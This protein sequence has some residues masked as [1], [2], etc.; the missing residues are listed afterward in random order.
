VALLS[1]PL[2]LMRILDDEPSS[3]APLPRSA[4]LAAGLVP[5]DQRRW[6]ANHDSKPLQLRAFADIDVQRY[7]AYQDIAG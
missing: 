4:L 5:G 6:S 7:S 3:T 2:V 1:G